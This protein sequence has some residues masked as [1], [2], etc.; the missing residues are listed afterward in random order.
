MQK[1]IIP[2]FLAMTHQSP[3]S[4]FIQETKWQRETGLAKNNELL[5]PTLGNRGEAT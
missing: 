4:T 2:R 3:L 5:S 1:Q